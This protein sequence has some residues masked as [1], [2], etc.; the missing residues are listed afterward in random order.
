MASTLV[1]PWSWCH[2]FRGSVSSSL[3]QQEQT[4]L[5]WSA[6]TKGVGNTSRHYGVGHGSV[7]C[8]PLFCIVLKICFIFHKR[9]VWC[10][11]KL[12][13]V[14]ISFSMCFLIFQRY[15]MSVISKCFTFQIVQVASL[16]FPYKGT[17]RKSILFK[18]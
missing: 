11:Q 14:H 2:P 13:I 10:T 8:R 6:S 3:N 15:K 7:L 12:Y 18:R 5:Q 16:Q 4:W 1:G 9:C 17:C